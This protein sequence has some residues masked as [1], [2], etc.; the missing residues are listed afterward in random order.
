MQL[1]F[2]EAASTLL[3]SHDEDMKIRAIL[4]FLKPQDEYFWTTATIYYNSQRI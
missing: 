1:G 4:G 2:N 3:G